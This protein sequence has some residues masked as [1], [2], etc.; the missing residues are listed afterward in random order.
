MIANATVRRLKYLLIK[1]ST[2]SPYL[3]IKNDKRKNR[4]D[5]LMAQASTNSGI[6]ILNAPEEIVNTLN[7]IGVKPAV[8]IMIK[9]CCSYRDCI[10]RKR[11]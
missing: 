6:G 9:P 5:L 1:S 2:F 11:F 4:A 7:G 3:T 10:S 8:N